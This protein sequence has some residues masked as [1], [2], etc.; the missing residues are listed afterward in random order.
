MVMMMMMI[1]ITMR[2]RCIIIFVVRVASGV[3]ANWVGPRARARQLRNALSSALLET[4]GA[5]LA[6]K[7][8]S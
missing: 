7:R 3:R 1:N 2:M 8:S 4:M 5:L 6:L